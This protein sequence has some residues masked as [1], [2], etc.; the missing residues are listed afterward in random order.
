LSAA[1][2]EEGGNTFYRYGTRSVIVE[3]PSAGQ[4]ISIAQNDAAR[5]VTT[6]SAT[7]CAGTGLVLVPPPG[8]VNCVWSTNFS[9][10]GTGS[11][12]LSPRTNGQVAFNSIGYPH[13]SIRCTLNY[14]L[15]TPAPCPPAP[16]V[17]TINIGIPAEPTVVAG[18]ERFGSGTLDLTIQ[19]FQPAFTY[20][21]YEDAALTA[22][23]H[24]GG[25]TFTTP[26]H[27]QSRSYYLVVT[28][29]E[30][31]RPEEVSVLLRRVRITVNGQVPTRP[32][33]GASVVLQADP[34]TG[35]PYTWLRDGE[36][37]N[38]AS[39]PQLTATEAGQYT[40]RLAGGTGPEYESLPVEV[41]P[42]TQVKEWTV[43]KPGVTDPQQVASLPVNE[44]GH[45][46]TY[47]NGLGQPV[48]QLA[49]QAGPGQEDVVQ[50][51]GY[52]GTSTTAQTFLP[53]P[54]ATTAK[55]SGE[56]EAD[57]LTKLNAYYASKGGLPFS[58]ATVEASPLGRPLEQTQTGQAWAGHSSRVSHESN[59]ATEVRR[60]QGFDGTQFYAAGQ[61]FKEVSA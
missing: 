5:N 44:R 24:T 3:N 28:S 56:Y 39:G 45:S 18:T 55:A 26:N 58:T 11:N 47:A 15:Q 10:P 16:L 27:N 4:F 38:D 48:Q 12:G 17:F 50:H 31:G 51:F 46:V 8:A 49:V 13:E 60:W 43:L 7:I 52:E 9:E 53:F 1:C 40:V 21:W 36:V 57:P 35:G 34:A 6:T 23:A 30:V 33:T 25:P 14:Q 32:V 54:V 59:T 41:L 37:I 61:L 29:C 22:V 2:V 42:F 20:T 19:N